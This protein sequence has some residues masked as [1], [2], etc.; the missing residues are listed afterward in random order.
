M[1]DIEDEAEAVESFNGTQVER[2]RRTQADMEELG[3][4]ATA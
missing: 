2:L 1:V 3:S 4:G